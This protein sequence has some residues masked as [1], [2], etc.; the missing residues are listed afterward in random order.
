MLTPIACTPDEH[1]WDVD[2]RW[3]GLF[4]RCSCGAR[5]WGQLWAARWANR[6]VRGEAGTEPTGKQG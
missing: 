3:P 2:G 6:V 4:E 1:A 5:R